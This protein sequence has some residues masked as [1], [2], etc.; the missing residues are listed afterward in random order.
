MDSIRCIFIELE[1]LKPWM[2][3]SLPVFAELLL[4]KSMHVRI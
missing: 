4:M 1:D 3:T 2:V